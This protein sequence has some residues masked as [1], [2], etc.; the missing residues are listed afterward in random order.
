MTRHTAGSLEIGGLPLWVESRGEGTP[1]LCISGLGYSAWCWDELRDALSVG[2][3][4][5]TFDNRG[6][7]RSAKPVGPYSIAMLADDTAGVLRALGIAQ[8]HVVG[9]SMG[10][11]ITQTL[12]LRHASLVRSVCLVGT[13]PGG[14]QAQPFPAETAAAWQAAA[15]LPPEQYARRTMPL[16]FAPGW[17]DTHPV[18]FEQ[19]LQRRL[20]YPTP[21]GC[22][23]AQYQA[24][25][26]YAA[27]GV[28]VQRIAVPALVVH[29]DQD[30]VVPFANGRLIAQRLPGA[31]WLPMAGVGH[32]PYLEQR[33]AFT[34][35]LQDFLPA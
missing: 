34:A 17:T 35:A 8:A 23:L 25:A 16:S 24:C 6:T 15:G 26:A 5:I 21:P 11:Y 31:R 2:H 20:Q 7:G 28:E 19:Y 22:W 4:V 1:V 10:G 14:P 30:R 32:V 33:Q 12:A 3:R 18:E 9:H 27:E 13:S 29:G